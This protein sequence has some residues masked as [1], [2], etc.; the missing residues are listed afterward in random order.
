MLPEQHK[1]LSLQ[2]LINESMLGNSRMQ[3]L[4]Y[5]KFAVTM[6]Y[7]CLRYLKNT[8][9]AEDVVQE[10]FIKV[11]ANLHKYRNEGSFEGWIRKIMTRS[12][13]SYLRDN[14]N[15][16]ITLILK[17]HMKLKNPI[18]LTPWPKKILHEL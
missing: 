9:D 6:Y 10:G 16:I 15:I 2:Y 12:A 7:Q 5:R 8:G 3:E 17:M 14:K 1:T 4:L 13:L 11:F 18:F